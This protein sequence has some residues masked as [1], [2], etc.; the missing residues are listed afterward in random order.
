MNHMTQEELSQLTDEAL[1]AKAKKMKSNAIWSALT[2][3]FMIGVVIYS[4]VENTFGFFTLIPL[5]FIYKMLNSS[6]NN[7]ALKQI[8]KE[9]GIV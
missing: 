5:Y 1:I 3:G 7:D 8:L 9:R 6:K 2:I 4:A